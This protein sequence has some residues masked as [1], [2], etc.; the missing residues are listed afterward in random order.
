MDWKEF[1]DIV[2]NG[3]ESQ[4]EKIINFNCIHSGID[5]TITIDE[6]GNPLNHVITNSGSLPIQCHL[7]LEDS[8]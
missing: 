3:G 5:Y 2:I 6:C 1:K 4:I 8:G 7:W